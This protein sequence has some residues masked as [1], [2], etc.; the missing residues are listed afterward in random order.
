M[1]EGSPAWSAGE[2]GRAVQRLLK[3]GRR[4]TRPATPFAD[5]VARLR[6]LAV[7]LGSVGVFAAMIPVLAQAPSNR[8]LAILAMVVLTVSIGVVLSIWMSQQQRLAAGPATRAVARERRLL[9]ASRQMAVSSHQDEIDQVVARTAH[10]LLGQETARAVVW[11]EQG[12][13]WV[14]IASAGPSRI[15]VAPTDQLPEGM[16]GRMDTGEP[17]VLDAA[18][19]AELQE[20]YGLEPRFRSYVYTPL[21]RR[22]GPQAVLALSCVEPPDPELAEVLRRFAQE[23]SMAED[24]ARL[25]AEVAEREAR[26]DSLLQG[27]SDIQAR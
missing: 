6:S 4:Q 9:A 11:E 1:S 8:P 26:L 7:P 23:V 24:R 18:E 25:L 14:A 2:D 21:P 15:D 19:S 13:V 22:Q 27:S 17:W 16:Y 5:V 3:A 10:D 12:D 20:A